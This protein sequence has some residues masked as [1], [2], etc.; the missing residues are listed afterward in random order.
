VAGD[1]RGLEMTQ[2]P[3]RVPWDIAIELQSLRTRAKWKQ[4][5]PA[6]TVSG[7]ILLAVE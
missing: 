6:L 7:D 1:E 2:V 5:N 4:G 3:G